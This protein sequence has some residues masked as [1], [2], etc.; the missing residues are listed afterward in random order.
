MSWFTGYQDF[1]IIVF[2]PV[3]TVALALMAAGGVAV[4]I[5]IIFR[6]STRF[7]KD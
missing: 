2:G 1:V 6:D 5:L 4:G 3:L 7:D